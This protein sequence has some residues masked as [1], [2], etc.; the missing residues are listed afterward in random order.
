MIVDPH[1][2]SAAGMQRYMLGAVAPRPI[3]LVSSIDSNG[4]VNLSPYS[5]FNFFGANPPIMIFSASRR[6]RNNTTKHTLEN[7]SET[8]EVVVNIVSF[9]MVEQ[10]SLSSTEYPKGTNEFIKSGLTEVPSLKI[11]P[12][13]VEESPVSFECKVN[14]I[15]PLGTEGGAGNLVICKVLLMHINDKILDQDHMIDPY[16]LDAVARMGGNW[17]SRA[18]GE[19]LFEVEKPLADQ[20]IGFD[21]LPEEVFEMGFSKN[22]LARL[23]NIRQ[24]PDQKVHPVKNRAEI[25][26]MVKIM[27]REK[28]TLGAWAHLLGLIDAEK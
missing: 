28:D 25:I 9:D 10:V 13:R 24:L 12:P 11:R 26:E 8:R 6:V 2:I 27:L 7:A 3:A 5:N 23:A 20:G 17:Y 16:K 21:Q 18:N 22:Q 4:N 15:V 14:D 19:V 1:E